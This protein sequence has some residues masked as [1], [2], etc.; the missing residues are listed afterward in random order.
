MHCTEFQMLISQYIDDALPDEQHEEVLLHLKDCVVCRSE[1]E[2]MRQI[3]SVA[4]HNLYAGPG[5]EYWRQ[6][7]EETEPQ[8][9][10]C[11]SGGPPKSCS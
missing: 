6:T 8:P 3:E 5:E 2:L 9:G 11:R 10:W 1:V 4:G 7:P